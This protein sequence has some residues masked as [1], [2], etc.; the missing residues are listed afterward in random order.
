VSRALDER[1]GVPHE[2]V[3]AQQDVILG[4]DAGRVMWPVTPV[5]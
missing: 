2:P 1:L 4:G 3:A 5:S